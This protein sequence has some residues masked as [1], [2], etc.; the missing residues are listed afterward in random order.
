MIV[1]GRGQYR[2]QIAIRDRWL[3]NPWRAAN[4]KLVFQDPVGPEHLQVKFFEKFEEAEAEART[5]LGLGSNMRVY[6][7]PVNTFYHR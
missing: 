2:A 5:S 6:V 4:I 3:S 1:A 7:V